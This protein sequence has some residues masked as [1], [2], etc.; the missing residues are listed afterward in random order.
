MSLTPSNVQNNLRQSK[1]FNPFD[2]TI[3]AY[4]RFFSIEISF[5]LK[6][7]VANETKRDQSD[8]RVSRQS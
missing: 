4:V 8:S 3:T 2:M 7:D 1:E 5:I 6:H